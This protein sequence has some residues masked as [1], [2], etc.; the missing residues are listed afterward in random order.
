MKNEVFGAL[1]RADKNGDRGGAE[2]VSNV[3][4]DSW[5][6]RR[7][8][9]SVH[10]LWHLRRR[11]LRWRF[12]GLSACRACHDDISRSG[13]GVRVSAGV[14]DESIVM[15]IG[16]WWYEDVRGMRVER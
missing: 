11:R 7:L 12:G 2:P 9:S 10:L 13:A 3:S 1:V 14:L 6:A 15:M 16:C 5:A 4:R 8:A